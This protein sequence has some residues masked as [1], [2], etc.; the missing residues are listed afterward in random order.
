MPQCP[1]T[2][3]GKGAFRRHQIR[4]QTKRFRP[5]TPPKCPKPHPARWTR[6]HRG[7]ERSGGPATGPR[8]PSRAMLARVACSKPKAAPLQVRGPRAPRVLPRDRQVV[9]KTL[10]AQAR[11]HG[12]RPTINRAQTHLLS[13]LYDIFGSVCTEKSPPR[14]PR[15]LRNFRNEKTEECC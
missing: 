4:A 7:G 5:Q 8:G 6:S 1:H 10:V 15:S 9:Q 2:G 3:G 14:A 13:P 12:P 11:S